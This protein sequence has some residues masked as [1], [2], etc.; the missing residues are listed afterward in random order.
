MIEDERL[1][2]TARTGKVIGR[3]F[4]SFRDAFGM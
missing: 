4:G 3:K 1:R 2:R